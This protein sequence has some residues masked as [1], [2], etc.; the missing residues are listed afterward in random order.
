M[1]LTKVSYSMIEGASVNV[2][3]FGADPTGVADSTQAFVDAF[4]AILATRTTGATGGDAYGSASVLWIPTG[5]YKTTAPITPANY[6][7]I[8]GENSIIEPTPTN[9]SVFNNIGY[10]TRFE[11]LIFAGGQ[12]ALDIATGN[13]DT[14][15]IIISGCEFH[16]QVTH[17]IKTNT[18]SASTRLTIQ[19]CKFYN[20]RTSCTLIAIASC[21]FCTITG[22]WATVAGTFVQSGSATTQAE[23]Y[24][25]G[26]CGV[27]FGGSTI[28]GINYST[29]TWY[30]CRFGGESAATGIVNYAKIDAAVP[31]ILSI[32]MCQTYF[33][34]TYVVDFVEL[35]N[36]FIC[37]NN[38][39]FAATDGFFFESA[40]SN[41]LDARGLTCDWIVENNNVESIEMRGLA[42][43]MSTVSTLSNYSTIGSS[44]LLV[45][46][47]VAQ[48]A[49][50]TATG[51]ALVNVTVTN[52]PGMFGQA[53]RTYVGANAAY[54][55]TISETWNNQLTGLT[56]GMYT[57]VF[58]I[59][60]QAVPLTSVI[61]LAADNSQSFNAKQGKHIVCIPFYWSSVTSTNRVGWSFDALNNAQ[62]VSMGSVRVFKGDALITS[63]N[64]QLYATAIPTTLRYEVGDRVIQ[65]TPTVGQPK[66]WACT[67]AGTPGTWVS[68]GNL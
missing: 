48:A 65:Q 66:A 50:N 28:W 57:A 49:S 56:T 44:T 41:L 60:V 6:C 16:D 47:K 1:S 19:N 68:E 26:V 2:L 51:G 31:N 12:I 27:P 59:D 10:A 64:N 40:I 24:V 25:S 15:T 35:P 13:V 32:Q 58:E 9:F 45:S 39:G 67:V 7:N 33:G 18:N 46:D 20:L 61:F 8:I 4:A 17:A 53:T 30:D 11:N 37:K 54:D 62:Q 5:K 55:G 52:T 63:S 3:D 36:T 23:V 38:R 43:A 34:G 14:T 29:M 22:G 21:D 42:G